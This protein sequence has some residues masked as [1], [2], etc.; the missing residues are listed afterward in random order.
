MVLQEKLLLA[1]KKDEIVKFRV[2]SG[3]PQ[4]GSTIFSHNVITSLSY[5]T[6]GM[7]DREEAG[8]RRQRIKRRRQG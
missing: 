5:R 2:A 3:L 4:P 1:C 6:V 7:C 8:L